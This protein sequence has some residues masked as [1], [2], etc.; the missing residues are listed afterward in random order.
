MARATNGSMRTGSL[1]SDFEHAFSNRVGQVFSRA[2]I[3]QILEETFGKFPVGSVVPTDHAEPSPD[4]V[5]QCAKCSYPEHRIFET[6]IDGQGKH[7]IARYR[8]R[9]FRLWLP[10]RRVSGSFRTGLQP[11]VKCG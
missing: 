3:R 9:D 6:I 2:E 8:V 1:H 7:G 10:R 5:N 11:W 4:H